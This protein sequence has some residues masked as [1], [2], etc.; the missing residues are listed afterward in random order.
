[1]P[2]PPTGHWCVDVTGPPPRVVRFPLADL[3][4]QLEAFVLRW[5][6]AVACRRGL[7]FRGGGGGDGA[8]RLR[9]PL[10]APRVQA[11]EPIVH[12]LA[13]LPGPTE[14]QL[15]LLLQAGAVAIGYWDGDQLLHH[16]AWKAYVVR[17]HGRAQPAY[18]KTRGR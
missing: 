16:K 17:G 15:V 8:A 13:R 12:Y 7:V 2:P 3:A 11:G 1:M 4:E 14:R 5:P 6:E 18:Q 9:V 10:A